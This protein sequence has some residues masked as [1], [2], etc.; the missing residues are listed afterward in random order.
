MYK[1]QKFAFHYLHFAL[2]LLIC[3]IVYQ[4]RWWRV[5][6]LIPLRIDSINTGLIKGFCL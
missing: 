4:M 2:E 5:K 1:L 3:G 6:L